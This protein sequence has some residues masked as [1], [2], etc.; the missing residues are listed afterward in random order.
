M[1]KTTCLYA[2]IATTI[3]LVAITIVSCQKEQ[4]AT[5]LP[6]EKSTLDRIREFQRQMDAV[7]SNHYEKT[8]TYMSIADAV[9]NIEALFNYNY[10]HTNNIYGKTVSS[11][12]TLYLPV[13][14]NDSV[15]L[16]DL[17]VFNGQMYE[18]VLAL[19]QDIVLDNKQFIILD[20]E[21]GEN[22]G[23]QANV[24][25]HTLQGSIKGGTPPTPPTPPQNGPFASGI[26]WYYGENGG[27]SNGFGFQEMDAADTLSGMLNYYLVPVAPENTEY[28]YTQVKMKYSQPG[29]LHYA[30]PFTGFPNIFPRYCEFYK[31]NPSYNDHWLNSDQMNFHFFGEKHLV[32]N[33]FP[34]DAE[35]PVPSGHTL[36]FVV[37]DDFSSD[38]TIEH[39]TTAYYGYC[40]AHIH[41]S[42]HHP[43]NL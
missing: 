10:A 18:A 9:W 6:T 25:I 26:S 29:N 15:S 35:D 43:G 17:C 41:D 19:Y 22:K 13:C 8:V 3:M 5:V 16:A 31:E 39:R 38:T 30:N 34:N 27:N 37:V 2:F 20:V 23:N 28:I 14:A 21:A 42:I 12:T 1:K 40:E 24:K 11:D 33:I 4:D 32:Q 7:E 36:F